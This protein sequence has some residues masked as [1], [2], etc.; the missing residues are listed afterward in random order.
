MIDWTSKNCGGIENIGK[1]TEEEKQPVS[2]ISA[3]IVSVDDNDGDEEGRRL[4]IIP[5]HLYAD[6]YSASKSSPPS[7]KIAFSGVWSDQIPTSDS[8]VYFQRNIAQ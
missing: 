6:L 7:I 8:N 3:S 5:P 2:T 1:A 4:K